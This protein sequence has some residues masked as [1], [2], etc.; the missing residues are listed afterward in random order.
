MLVLLLGEVAGLYTVYIF[1]MFFLK[2]LKILNKYLEIYVYFIYGPLKI[3][4][5]PL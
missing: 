3:F 1:Q 2:F 4:K 5:G